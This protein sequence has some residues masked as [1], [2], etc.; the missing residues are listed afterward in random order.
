MLY[1]LRIINADICSLQVVNKPIVLVEDISL[2]DG[3]LTNDVQKD[4]LWHRKMVHA[5]YSKCASLLHEKK[6]LR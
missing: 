3:K 2:F 1:F 4:S 6:F 5:K